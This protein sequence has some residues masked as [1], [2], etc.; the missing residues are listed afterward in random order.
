MRALLGMRNPF[1]VPLLV[2]A[3]FL[4]P[5]PGIRAQVGSVAGTVVDATSGQPMPS[6]QVFIPN[7]SIGA[8]SNAQGRYLIVNVP[9][10]QQEVRAEAIGHQPVS[11]T[12]TVT[13]GAT[14]S[15]SFRME[16]RAISMGEIVVT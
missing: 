1:A 3:L 12:V 8:L 11:Q 7:R 16:S 14:A 9:V 5:V 10:G 2:C 4:L 13:A 15:A 6:V